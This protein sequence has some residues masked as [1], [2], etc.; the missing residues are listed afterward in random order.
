MAAQGK[1]CGNAI[2]VDVPLQGGFGPGLPISGDTLYS[3]TALGVGRNDADTDLYADVD[4]T[5]SFDYTLG[6]STGGASC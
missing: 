6:S 4:A 5:P 2:V 1:V 3:V